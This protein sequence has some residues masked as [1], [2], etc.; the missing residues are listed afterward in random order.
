MPKFH[1]Q[2][3]IHGVAAFSPGNL[4]EKMTRLL[5]GQKN[6]S[7]SG[8]SSVSLGLESSKVL[9]VGKLSET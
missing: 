8:E 4:G 5:V 2:I 3:C 9:L 1:D 6:E 7:T